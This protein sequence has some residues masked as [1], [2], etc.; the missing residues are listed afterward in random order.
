MIV[1]ASLAFEFGVVYHNTLLAFCWVIAS[2]G[3]RVLAVGSQTGKEFLCD[4]FMSIRAA[5][6]L[7]MYSV[8]GLI[9]HF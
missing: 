7:P 8:P 9:D 1:S 4:V 3:S 6:P 5:R 2:V